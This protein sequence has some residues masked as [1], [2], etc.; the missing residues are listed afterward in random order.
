MKISILLVLLF[1]WVVVFATEP[2]IE[3]DVSEPNQYQITVEI[4][5]E[6]EILIKTPKE[7]NDVDFSYA[8][9]IVGD[10]KINSDDYLEVP[11]TSLDENQLKQIYFKS[12]KNNLKD[13]Q[14]NILYKKPKLLCIEAVFLLTGFEHLNFSQNWRESDKNNLFNRVE[15]L[16]KGMSFEK[17][18]EILGRPRYESSHYPKSL[19]ETNNGHA[20]VYILNKNDSEDRSK[21]QILSIHFNHEFEFKNITSKNLMLDI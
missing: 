11:L 8:I 12:G 7:Y 19:T 6:N 1:Y 10:Q 9:L 18:R 13:I 3:I 5:K 4:L 21:D 20:L 14:V 2:F 17:V 16:K 15:K